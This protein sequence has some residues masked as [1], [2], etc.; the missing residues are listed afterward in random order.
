MSLQGTF[1]T[2]NVG[3][4]INTVMAAAG[5]NGRV[6]AGQTT[7]VWLPSISARGPGFR[8]SVKFVGGI[9]LAW[10]DVAVIGSGTAPV[11]LL[12]AVGAY[13]ASM[14]ITVQQQQGDETAGG[15]ADAA[16]TG[17]ESMIGQYTGAAILQT[18]SANWTKP[19]LTNEFCAIRH[20]IAT[21]DEQISQLQFVVLNGNSSSTGPG[22]NILPGVVIASGPAVANTYVV[23]EQMQDVVPPMDFDIAINNGANIF[24]V[25][26]KTFTEPSGE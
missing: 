3:N 16:M 23:R 19:G 20:I 15:F 17:L 14:Q 5:N 18:M 4:A 11:P 6:V 22:T 25:N 9:G 13:S 10:W 7:L 26:S 1:Y 8:A 12:W 24:S 2:S 21:Q